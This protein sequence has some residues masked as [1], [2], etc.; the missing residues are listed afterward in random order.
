MNSGTVLVCDAGGNLGVTESIHAFSGNDFEMLKSSSLSRPRCKGIGPTY[1]AFTNY[2]GFSDQESGKTMALAAYGDSSDFRDPLFEFNDDTGEVFGRLNRAHQV[3]VVEFLREAGVAVSPFQEWRNPWSQALAHYA[4]RELEGVL[5]RLAEY[6][7]RKTGMPGL[8]LSG[9]VGLNSIANAR[10]RELRPFRPTF[11]FPVCSDTGLALGDALYGQ[12]LLSGEIP[13]QRDLSMLFGRPYAEAEL[14]AALRREPMTTPPARLRSGDFSFRRSRDI[15][16]E[17]AQRLIEGQTVAWFQ[18]GSECGPRALGARSILKLP[19][20]ERYREELNSLKGREWFRPFGPAVLRGDAKSLL[21]DP[22]DELR[23]MIE[24]PRVSA[25]GTTRLAACTHVDGTSRVQVVDSIAN[26]RFG[27]LLLRIKQGTGVG[28][29]M[30]T[31]FN[32]H[33]PIVESPGDAIRTFLSLGIDFLALED[34]G[35]TLDRW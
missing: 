33:E 30:N 12:W 14:L 32:V 21:N 15:V 8:C 6:A 2:L 16:E 19:D 20:K 11:F 26:E 22:C 4:Q 1:E 31:S 17:V 24:A 13:R 29:V 25:M 23:Y 28:A 10:L 27:D 7:I 34:Y 9:G 35:C 18:G 3:G 5:C